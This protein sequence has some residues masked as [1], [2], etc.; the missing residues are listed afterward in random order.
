MIP[1]TDPAPV[2]ALH[3]Q[4]TPALQRDPN[5]LSVTAGLCFPDEML[6][7]PDIIQTTPI[8]TP[9]REKTREAPFQLHLAHQMAPNVRYFAFCFHMTPVISGK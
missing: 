5:R 9:P 8:H 3:V 2:R 4:V 6:N 7:G 1:G